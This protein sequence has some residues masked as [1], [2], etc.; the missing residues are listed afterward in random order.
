MNPRSPG[1]FVLTPRVCIIGG[2]PSGLRAAADLAP[3]VDGQV[4][5][6][7]REPE[8]GGIPRHSD[9]LGYGLRDLGRFTT[10]P[11]Y[12]RA[13]RERALTAGADIRTSTMATGWL[14]DA[15]I[16]VTC[17]DG[18]GRVEPDVVILATGARERPRAARLIP[19]ARCEGVY[20]TGQLQNLVHIKHREIGQRAVILG[21]ELVSWSAVLTLKHAGCRTALMV[22]EHERPE[23][24][25]IFNALG[26]GLLRTPVATNTKLVRILGDARVTAV[27]IENLSTGQRRV[28]ECDT[29]IL[30]GD[31]IPDNELAREAGLV[32]DE[33]SKAPI[34]DSA[35]SHLDDQ[36][37]SPSATSYI[38]STQQMLQ[39][40]TGLPLSP[41]SSRTS[42]VSDSRRHSS[43]SWSSRHF[44]GCRLRKSTSR[45]HVRRV[46]ASCCGP[47]NFELRR[48]SNFAKADCRSPRVASRGL[49]L[50]DERSDFR[51]PYST[52]SIPARGRSRSPSARISIRIIG[53]RPSNEESP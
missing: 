3:R 52:R 10:G 11:R 43:T 24:Y 34:T 18:R 26:R 28:F 16:A 8:A 15:S 35:S 49:L 47:T 44:V 45:S 19:G 12:A 14:G 17:P 48:A 6:L 25:A 37:C 29:V 46:T 38:R 22:T 39:R 2:G 4:I 32:L 33:V 27:E 7:E 31:W 42:Q 20:T 9:H 21:A 41:T 30:T 5:V 23:S 53:H 51:H 13:L 1:E 36:A 40:S 50:Q